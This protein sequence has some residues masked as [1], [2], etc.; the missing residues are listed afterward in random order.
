MT[1]AAM[2]T[3]E[4]ARSRTTEVRLAP[5]PPS[6]AS[7]LGDGGVEVGAAIQKFLP[8]EALVEVKTG[9][10][11]SYAAAGSVAPMNM[12]WITRR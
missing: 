3:A 10:R 4:M 8:D 9:A 1:T 2:T 12:Y 6:A 5:E 7:E 11:H